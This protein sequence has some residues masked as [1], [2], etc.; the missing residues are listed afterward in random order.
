MTKFIVKI[1]AALAL[2]ANTLTAAPVGVEKDEK[3]NEQNETPTAIS[4]LSAAWYSSDGSQSEIFISDKKYKITVY[5]AGALSKWKQECVKEKTNVYSCQG[6]IV[7]S[8]GIEYD[9][10]GAISLSEDGSTLV[11]TWKMLRGSEAKTNGKTIYKRKANAT[12][13]R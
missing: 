2:G 10:L 7:D 3:T 8:S 11:E 6:G 4:K 13:V 5:G 1:V 12:P 9:I